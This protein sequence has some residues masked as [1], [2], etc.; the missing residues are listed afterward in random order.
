MKKKELLEMKKMQ[1]TTHMLHTAEQDE[2]KDDEIKRTDR[3]KAEKESTGKNFRGHE[4][5]RI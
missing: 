1:A 5:R 2:A 3:R 4:D